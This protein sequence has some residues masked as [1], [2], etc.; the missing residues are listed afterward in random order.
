MVTLVDLILGMFIST[1]VSYVSFS[2][3]KWLE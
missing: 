2:I 3:G 1:L